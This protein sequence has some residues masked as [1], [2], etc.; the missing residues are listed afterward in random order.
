MAMGLL[1]GGKTKR[2][3]K[4]PRMCLYCGENP[5]ND[6][7]LFNRDGE[8]YVVEAACCSI[9]CLVFEFECQ[10]L[11]AEFGEV[12]ETCGQFKTNCGYKTPCGD[13]PAG[14]APKHGGWK[15]DGTLTGKVQLVKLK[16]KAERAGGRS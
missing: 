2:T 14:L 5:A 9:K 13:Q 15:K 7:E 3:E 1:K 8:G 4:L 12:C 10:V 11:D 16:A 6:M